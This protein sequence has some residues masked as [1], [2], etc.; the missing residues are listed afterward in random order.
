VFWCLLAFLFFPQ[1]SGWKI[2]G[3]VLLITVI[4][5][6]LQLVH[7]TFLEVIRDTYIGKALIGTNFNPIDCIFYF[8][9]GGIGILW[10]YGIKK[11]KNKDCNSTLQN[12]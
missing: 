8:L 4:L 2:V 3:I 7:P 12:P 9:G 6:F 11:Q 1:T 10:I 5:E